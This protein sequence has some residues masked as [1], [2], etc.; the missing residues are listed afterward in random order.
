MSK[1]RFGIQ[2]W[3]VVF[4]FCAGSIP[5]LSISCS[6]GEQV[7]VPTGSRATNLSDG[8]G[9]LLSI[10][11]YEGGRDPQDRRVGLLHTLVLLLDLP[12]SAVSNKSERSQGVFRQVSEWRAEDKSTGERQTVRI[13]VEFEFLRQR[14]V[15]YGKT[16]DTRLGNL[17]VIDLSDEG[18][19]HAWQLSEIVN[20]VEASD[21]L[22]AFKEG[23]PLNSVVQELAMHPSLE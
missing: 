3:L 8:I 2:K 15:L 13:V 23:L 10:E 18:S 6:P 9:E 16:F 4:A 22:Q 5:G 7:G 11:G 1:R 14:V 21:A 12:F 20:S 19:E 17:F